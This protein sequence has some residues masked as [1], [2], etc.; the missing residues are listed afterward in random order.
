MLFYKVVGRSMKIHEARPGFR[1]EQFSYCISW[2]KDTSGNEAADVS[3]QPLILPVVG[4]HLWHS[5]SVMFLWTVG[6][7]NR[8]YLV[9]DGR[10]LRLSH[11]TRFLWTVAPRSSDDIDCLYL[12]RFPPIAVGR[13]MREYDKPS[14]FGY[15]PLPV[16]KPA[17]TKPSRFREETNWAWLVS[18]RISLETYETRVACFDCVWY[19]D[20][21]SLQVCVCVWCSFGMR[22]LGLSSQ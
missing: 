1:R 8:S 16:I 6:N 3:G 2:F 11:D 19:F 18:L 14:P 9:S 15:I 12:H 13:K 17:V 21:L 7:M 4:A 22:C 20:I 5:P 10:A